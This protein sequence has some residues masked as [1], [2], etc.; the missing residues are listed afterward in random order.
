MVRADGRWRCVAAQG[1]D[2]VEGRCEGGVLRWRLQLSGC[3]AMELLARAADTARWCMQMGA[4]G[5]QLR[6]CLMVLK[7]DQQLCRRW[8]A[9]RCEAMA[10]AGSDWAVVLRCE[11]VGAAEVATM[12]WQL[13]WRVRLAMALRRCWRGDPGAELVI[14]EAGSRGPEA[15]KRTP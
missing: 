2:G 13:R 14:Q 6:K 8:W 15:Y 11:A 9:G 3:E 1:F 12:R 7:A 10:P 5:V 4:G